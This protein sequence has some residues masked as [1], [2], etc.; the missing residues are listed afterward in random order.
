MWL[1]NYFLEIYSIF[2]DWSE[3][4]PEKH[5]LMRLLAAKILESSN[6]FAAGKASV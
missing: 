5:V 3:V 6:I 2:V 1:L 4:R